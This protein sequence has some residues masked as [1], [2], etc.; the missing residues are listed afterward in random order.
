MEKKG[1]IIKRIGNYLTEVRGELKKVTWPTKNDLIK[2]TI[3]VL[4]ASVIFGIYLTSVDTLFRF[5]F[6]Y[7][8]ELFK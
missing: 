2:T 3:A 7:I 5:V 1:N 4:V 8:R 6:D